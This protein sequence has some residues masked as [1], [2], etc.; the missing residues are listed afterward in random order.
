[1]S[2]LWFLFIAYTKDTDNIFG[3]MS[4]AFRIASTEIGNTGVKQINSNTVSWEED[5]LS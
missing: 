5:R 1:M 2:R 3:K 4:E